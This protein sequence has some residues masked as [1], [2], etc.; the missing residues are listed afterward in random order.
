LSHEREVLEREN[1][2]RE[3]RGIRERV[4]EP[5]GGRTAATDFTA[6]GRWNDPGYVRQV[7]LL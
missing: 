6:G 2:N 3:R 4:S 7:G 5:G 1:E